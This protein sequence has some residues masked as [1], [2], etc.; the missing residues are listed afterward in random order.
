MQLDAA[1]EAKR[2]DQESASGDHDAPAAGL[3]AFVDCALDCGGV[4]GLAVAFRA[5]V[6]HVEAT[7]PP[8]RFRRSRKR[9]TGGQRKKRTAA[10]NNSR[11]VSH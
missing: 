2:L 8:R 7:L 6:A 1:A 10:D 3:R 11:E 9:R 5:V 4:E